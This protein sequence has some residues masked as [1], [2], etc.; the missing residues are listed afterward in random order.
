MEPALLFLLGCLVVALLAG[1]GFIAVDFVKLRLANDA[2]E[3]TSCSCRHKDCKALTAGI[4]NDIAKLKS[5]LESSA[6]E[7]GKETLDENGVCVADCQFL[8]NPTS[9]EFS[10]A[11]IVVV[12]LFIV[13]SVVIFT[14]RREERVRR[15]LTRISS[16]IQSAGSVSYNRLS[17]LGML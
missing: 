7:C 10:I 4:R 14:Q 6:N 5:D 17:R 2:L 1:L 9:N 3:E 15:T 13:A 12:T 16:A 11:I 8:V